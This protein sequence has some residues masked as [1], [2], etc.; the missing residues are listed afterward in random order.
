MG[1]NFLI[2]KGVHYGSVRKNM[3]K[4]TQRQ[5]EVLD[6]IADSQAQSGLI[7]SSREIQKHFGFSSQTAAINHLRALERKGVIQK[8]DG[9]ARAA[10]PMSQLERRTIIDVPLYGQIA[11]GYSETTEQENQG[12]VSID[13]ASIGLRRGQKVFALKVRGDSMIGAGIYHGDLVIL[14]NRPPVSGAVVAALID[15]ETTLKRYLVERE[16]PFLHAE[17]PMFPDLIPM[18]ELIIQGVLV[19]LIRKF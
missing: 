9:R 11:A 5:Q 12:L 6:F 15:G 16:R 1:S 13:A 3:N 19:G 14:E 18:A 8:A 4:L 2:A 10:V 7:P 17:N